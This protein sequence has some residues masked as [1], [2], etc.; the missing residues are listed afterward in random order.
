MPQTVAKKSHELSINLDRPDHT[1]LP[2]ETITGRISRKSHIVAP[3][4]TISITLHARSKS[5][6]VARRGHLTSTYRGRFDLLKTEPYSQT[7]FEGPLHIT[8]DG[9]EQSW[10]FSIETPHH[11][12]LSVLRSLTHPDQSFLSSS[13]PGTL[14][15]TFSVDRYEYMSGMSAFVEYYLQAELQT[16]SRGSGDAAGAILPF[17]ML[18]INAEPFE[19]RPDLHTSRHTVAVHG[20]NPMVISIEVQTPTVLEIDCPDPMPFL[21]WAVPSHTLDR[22]DQQN[23]PHPIW[24]TRVFMN[25]IAKTEIKCP[26]GKGVREA[27]CQTRINLRAE[28]AY[29][30]YGDSLHIPWKLPTTGEQPM[31]NNIQ[32]S[33][34]RSSEALDIGS[35]IDLHLERSQDLYASFQT[36]N[37]RHTHRLKWEM[38]IEIS[39]KNFELAGEDPITI[40]GRPE[41]ERSTDWIQPP[42]EDYLPSF[43]DYEDSVA[44]GSRR[45]SRN[46]IESGG[47]GG[48]SRLWVF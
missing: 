8:V 42:P 31:R 20:D 4:A 32:E 44:S 39:G 21:A 10:P 26:K 41:A 3:S 15:P 2:G 34:V 17:R 24:I 38:T 19:N 12:N 45:S 29:R 18:H 13:M 23:G 35:K 27:E 40:L 11:P 30:R 22:E 33:E 25:V 5:R 46:T 14:P 9:G 7:I 37:I 36:F 28:D 1:Y 48:L 6:M 16:A 43:S 47:V